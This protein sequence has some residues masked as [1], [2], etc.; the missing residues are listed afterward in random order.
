MQVLG[1]LDRSHLRIETTAFVLGYKS[2][3]RGRGSGVLHPR[4]SSTLR[5]AS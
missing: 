3:G 5:R 1:D 2:S 4:D